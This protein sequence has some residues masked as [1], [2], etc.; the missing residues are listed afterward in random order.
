VEWN[1]AG[2]VS[3]RVTCDAEVMRLFAC[4][5]TGF[6]VALAPSAVAQTTP[7]VQS[8]LHELARRP[9]TVTVRT[10]PSRREAYRAHARETWESVDFAYRPRRIQYDRVAYPAPIQRAIESELRS[11]M[12]ASMAAHDRHDYFDFSLHCRAT[13]ATTTLVVYLCAADAAHPALEYRDMGVQRWWSTHAWEVGAQLHPLSLDDLLL[14]NTEWDGRV[15]TPTA[16]GVIFNANEAGLSIDYLAERDF[17]QLGPLLNMRSMLQ[18]IPNAVRASETATPTREEIRVSATP[19]PFA[20]AVLDATTL[21]S[22]WLFA[23]DNTTAALVMQVAPSPESAPCPPTPPLH[24]ESLVLTRPAVLR[25]DPT[26]LGALATGATLPANTFVRGVVG[27]FRAGLS[28]IA[29]G[30]SV[31]VVASEGLVGWLPADALRQ[32]SSAGRAVQSFLGALPV[33]VRPDVHASLLGI[34]DVVGEGH[35]SVGYV[36]YGP[37]P[38]DSPGGSVVG[39]VRPPADSGP[40]SAPH[41]DAQPQPRFSGSLLHAGTLVDARLVS[42]REGNALMLLAWSLPEDATHHQWEAY[43]MANGNLTHESVFTLT[44]GLPDGSDAERVIVVTE[45]ERRH[46][47]Y[48]FVVRGPGRSETLYTWNGTTLVAAR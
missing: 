37:H 6:A 7:V 19:L 44:L 33:E 24:V 39:F 46:V 5:V 11:I 4:F 30:Q 45:L 18:R 29:P 34:I 22:R 35:G 28:S 48:P 27:T 43:R 3:G 31:L 36:V 47:Y 40:G 23:P 21:G 26:R 2:R 14:P 8:E 38:Q 10:P 15:M 1:D 12:R 9:V 41:D 16:T 42:L 17:D 32:S 13:L 20:R 25:A